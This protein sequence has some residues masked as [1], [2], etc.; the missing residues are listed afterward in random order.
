MKKASLFRLKTVIW[1]LTLKC[2]LD[3]LHCGS[4]AKKARNDEL[5]TQEA[6]KFC[7]D[8]A[9]LGVE[10]VCLI[11]G[12]PFLRGDWSI[13]AEALKN[14]GVGWSII[15]NGQNIRKEI[16][17]LH[18]LRP[19]TV[20]ISIDGAKAE[21]HDRIRG[22][23]GAFKHALKSIHLLK[24]ENIPTSV[25]TSVNKLNFKELKGIR[26]LLANS[27]IAWQIQNCIP[28]GRFSH[29]LMLSREEYYA[30]ALFMASTQANFNKFKIYVSGAHDFGYFSQ[31]LP[32]IQISQW[33]GCR[34]G[35]S[36]IGVQSNGNIK[37]CLS[38]PDKFIEGNIREESII[39]IW[40]NSEKF[41]MN[42]ESNESTIKITTDCSECIKFKHCRGGCQSFSYTLTGKFFN[43]P[44]CLL[45]YEN[46]N[47]QKKPLFNKVYTNPVF[48]KLES[49]HL[50][51]KYFLS[52][53]LTKS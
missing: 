39:N 23:K 53:N 28:I 6:L 14:S 33:M 41:K 30:V 17:R 32:N 16:P 51:A 26:K 49:M 34:A 10:K 31:F 44:Y 40:Y 22:K 35:I 47:F 11:G 37:G 7:K 25:I 5:T 18:E 38:L 9:K 42:R 15:S 24:R 36:V 52:Q 8:L 46:Q 43:H 21:T 2:N 12:E 19:Y 48:S 3:C 1:E 50:K 29:E 27:K 45:K 20:G 4:V 13:I